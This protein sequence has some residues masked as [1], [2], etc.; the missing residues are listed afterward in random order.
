[1]GQREGT[2]IA[3]DIVVFDDNTLAIHRVVDLLLALELAQVLRCLL[4]ARGVGPGRRDAQDMAREKL[5]GGDGGRE[6]SACLCIPVVEE[7][8]GGGDEEDVLLR[9]RALGQHG[10]LRESGQKWV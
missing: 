6:R 4:P 5:F 8:I 10:A 7:Y 3:V 9:R 1:M 2:L